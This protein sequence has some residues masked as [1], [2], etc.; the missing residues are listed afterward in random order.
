[1][2]SSHLQFP[3]LPKNSQN[4]LKKALLYLR[5]NDSKEPS[6]N[7]G[8]FSIVE[9]REYV[10]QFLEGSQQDAN[11][12]NTT[13][14][15][16]KQFAENAI[17]NLTNDAELLK[18]FYDKFKK[19]L[20]EFRANSVELKPLPEETLCEVKWHFDTQLFS[21]S[22]VFYEMDILDTAVQFHRNRYKTFVYTILY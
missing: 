10:D 1:M 4:E 7:I 11:K 22:L 17:K 18:G 8:T 5:K 20:S 9:L 21:I 3:I 12:S 13:K 19:L 15:V 14:R 6:S 16:N 2:I